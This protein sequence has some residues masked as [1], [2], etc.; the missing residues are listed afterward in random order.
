[1]VP[2]KA[3]AAIDR[4]REGGVR[5]DRQPDVGGVRA[6]L[7]GQRGDAHILSDEMEGES[8]DR[9]DLLCSA[10]PGPARWPACPGEYGRTISKCAHC[11]ST[12]TA[13]SCPRG[14]GHL[15]RRDLCH[16]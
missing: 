9:L 11:R 4:F 13:G 2:S 6:Q 12:A 5:A 16:S 10:R 1:M 15:S 14:R 7:N 8:R 3:S